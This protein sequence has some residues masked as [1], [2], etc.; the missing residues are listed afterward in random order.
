MFISRI[1]VRNFRNLRHIDTPLH[2]GV[3]GIVGE[4]NSG[5]SNAMLALR[6]C[7]DVDL[8]SRLR[9]LAPSDVHTSVDLTKPF[10]VLIGVEFAN[11]SENLSELALLHACQISPDRARIFYRFRPKRQVRELIA[12]GERSA[13][14]LQL[15]DYGWEIYGGGNPKVDLND[16]EWNEDTGEPIRFSDLQYFQVVSLHALRDV[17]Q[18]LRNG[19]ASPLVK[20][21]D[22][23]KVTNE[24]QAEFI[25][26]LVAA[27]TAIASA[28]SLGKTAAGIEK[29]LKE[30]TGPS[31]GIGTSIG[32]VDP[33]Y[34]SILRSLKILLSEEDGL[35]NADPSKNGLGL[36]NVLYIAIW[37][38]YLRARTKRAG[39]AGQIILIEEPEAHLHP[40]LQ[41]SLVSALS[42]IAMQTI[43]TTHST[44]IT[45]RLPLA[46]QVVMTRRGGET[47]SHAVSTN[48][49]LS[50]EDRRDLERYLDATKSTLL[51][52]RKIILVEGAA[53]LILLPCLVHEMMEIDLEKHGISVIS[54]NGT[55]FAPFMKLLEGGKLGKRCVVIGDADLPPIAEEVEDE[56]I[57]ETRADLKALE[58]PAVKVFLGR[59][60]FERELA[61]VDNAPML[62][63]ATYESGLQ[64]ASQRLALLA[65]KIKAF[66]DNDVDRLPLEEEFRDKV[67]RVAIRV[68][69]ARFAQLCAAYIKQ[70]VLIPEYIS[71]AVDWLVDE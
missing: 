60:T 30:V 2:S 8:P 70:A 24:E 62:V 25:R 41:L 45:A 31:Y 35:G 11:F 9:I 54:V 52:A 29:A 19:R 51:F 18:D 65:Q 16:M 50:P 32:V 15:E 63:A 68:G 10:Q 5:K 40:Q 6:I 13:D 17:E 67:L 49:I 58:G 44:H 4:N 33:T 57:S 69:K 61:D 56:D 12:S 23:K 66:S 42:D 59:T 1:V 28:D 36:N 48:A 21:L 37:L 26:L 22:T 46:S 3:N 55:H 20:L 43:L 47:T 64:A 27:N 34:E 14:D 39:S 71:D 38:E 7:L 53:E